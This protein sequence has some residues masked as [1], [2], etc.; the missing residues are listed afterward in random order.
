[1][2]KRWGTIEYDPVRSWGDAVAGVRAWQRSAREVSAFIDFAAGILEKA[3]HPFAPYW[4]HR[5]KRHD[6][7]PRRGSIFTGDDIATYSSFFLEKE[8]PTYICVP[9]ERLSAPVFYV[10]PGLPRCST[11]VDAALSTYLDLAVYLTRH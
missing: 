11:R 1:M 3:H 5:R 2:T 8:L 7:S 6:I 4:A 9:I 10:E